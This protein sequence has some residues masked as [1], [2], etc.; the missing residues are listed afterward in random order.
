[1]V[2][3]VTLWVVGRIPPWIAVISHDRVVALSVELVQ[4]P[5]GLDGVE[6]R[7]DI[8]V[9]RFECEGRVRWAGSLGEE[10]SVLVPDVDPLGQDD[11]EFSGIYDVI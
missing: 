11:V 6:S 9:P 1:M 7:L 5:A 8:G 3:G 4:R 2:G 10:M